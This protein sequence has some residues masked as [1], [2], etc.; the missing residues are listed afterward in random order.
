MNRGKGYRCGGAGT[1]QVANSH[2]QGCGK[3]DGRG[4]EATRS[5]DLGLMEVV[6][7]SI[8]G[9][10]G[11][12][13]GCQ[14]RGASCCCWGAGSVFSQLSVKI[15]LLRLSVVEISVCCAKPKKKQQ[16]KKLVLIISHAVTD[17]CLPPKMSKAW[18]LK[19]QEDHHLCPLKHNY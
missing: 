16:K 6:V 11:G 9:G 5:S 10:G 2:L 8:G 4:A 12:R 1:V 17:A 18:F 3:G 7:G 15:A 14:G 19:A 13:C